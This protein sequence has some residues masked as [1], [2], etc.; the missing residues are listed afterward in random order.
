MKILL[1]PSEIMAYLYCPRFIYFGFCLGLS[2]HEEKRFK[3]LKGRTIHEDKTKINKDYLRKK[4]GVMNKETEVYL[5]SEKLHIRGIVDEVLTLNDGT[6]APL[7]YKFAEYKQRRFKTHKTQSLA[8]A[9]LISENYSMP[10]KKG[11]VIYT[12]SRNKLVD[13]E[14]KQKDIDG[15]QKII[16]EM[17]LI[18]QKGFYPK[19]TSSKAK[20]DDCAFRNICV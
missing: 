20:C 13:I 4:I 12:R 18:I 16:E 17:L 1:T 11:F 7:D 8:Y 10:A 2:E 14:F 5:S 19:K 6:M 3:V 15:F 9:M